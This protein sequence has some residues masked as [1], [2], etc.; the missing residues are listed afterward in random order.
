MKPSCLSST[1]YPNWKITIFPLYQNIVAQISTV[2]IKITDMPTL[3]PKC[4]DINKTK[5]E[6]LLV[7]APIN[8][9]Y[10]LLRRRNYL[11]FAT[12][13]CNLHHLPEIN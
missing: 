4:T 6:L 12:N 10:V 8:S 3:M 11:L 1:I 5:K 2:Q 13:C 7:F 9:P